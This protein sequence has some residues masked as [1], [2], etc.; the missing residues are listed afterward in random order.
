MTSADV[1]LLYLFFAKRVDKQVAAA[2][3]KVEFKV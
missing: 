3:Q 1:C 2:A